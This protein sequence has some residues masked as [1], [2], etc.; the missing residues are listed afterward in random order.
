MM[1]EK[2][3]S[4]RLFDTIDERSL[5]ALSAIVRY[6]TYKNGEY[7]IK[8]GLDSDGVYILFSGRVK[9][10]IR[11]H[12]G[13]IVVLDALQAGRIFGTLSAIDKK[14]RGANC[15]A[16]GDVEVGYIPLSD[17]HDLL[18]GA[19]PLALGFQIAI[20][21]SLFDE[22]RKTNTQ[23]SELSALDAYTIPKSIGT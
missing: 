3:S 10:T 20:L 12:T 8:Q 11:T 1:Q 18:K 4:I 6:K 14:E 15:V 7:I 16:S 22:I 19:S 13:P 5:N 2:L 23:V 9:I 21:R 17:F